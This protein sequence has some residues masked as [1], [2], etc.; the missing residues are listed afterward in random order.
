MNNNNKI[1][2]SEELKQKLTEEKKIYNTARSSKIQESVAT[3]ILEKIQQKYELETK[4][5][6]L[7]VIAILFQQGGTAK[8]CDG[9]MSIRIFGKDFKLADIRKCMKE[10]SH[11]K[12]ERKLARTLA[13]QIF[14][15]SELME[16]PGNLYQKIQKLDLTRTFENSEKA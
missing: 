4:E 6:A 8:S 11:P 10:E 14:Q 2:I 9:N 7:T 5:E 16:I 1:I 13:N 12:S 3:K 15:I